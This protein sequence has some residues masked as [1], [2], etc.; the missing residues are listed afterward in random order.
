VQVD[1]LGRQA[2]L[3][4]LG[5]PYIRSGEHTDQLW[6]EIKQR[7]VVERVTRP[8]SIKLRLLSDKT[9]EDSLKWMVNMQIA[10]S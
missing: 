7:S 6:R 4:E 1:C 9:A 2:D 10:L 8:M 5:I 3:I